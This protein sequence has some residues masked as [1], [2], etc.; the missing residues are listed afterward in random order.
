MHKEVFLSALVVVHNEEENL[1]SCLET[2]KFCDEI[3]VVLDNCQDGSEKI[4]KAQGCKILKG[5]W[6]I[7]GDR[8]NE[9]IEICKGPWILEIDADERVSKEL[10]NEIKKTIEKPKDYAYFTIP[11]DNYIGNHCVRFGWGAYFGVGSVK[12]L[13]RKGS[14]VWGKQRV[15]PK[16]H[17]LGKEGYRFSNR[18]IHYVDKDIEDMIWRLNRY[19]TA[20]AKDLV[21]SDDIKDETLKRN[22]R[23]IFSRFYKCYIRKKGYKEGNYGFLVA[24]CAGLYPILSYLKARLEEGKY[25]G[26]N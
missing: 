24:L 8:R 13:F 18:L 15:H 16:V 20:R 11:V 7:E 19:T 6:P 4:A 5:S 3:V 10:A 2:L 23:R 17:F 1:K 21:E 22:I 25:S 26:K 12:R 9:G 14:K